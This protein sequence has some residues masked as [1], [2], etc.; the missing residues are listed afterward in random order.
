MSDVIV[1]PL[2]LRGAQA[3]AADGPR[4]TAAHNNAA[5]RRRI[6]ELKA[7]LAGYSDPDRIRT[8]DRHRPNG[9]ARCAWIGSHDEPLEAIPVFSLRLLAS[10]R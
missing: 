6:V 7:R 8:D 9:L 5:R 1:H 2:Q 4:H 10:R 3:D